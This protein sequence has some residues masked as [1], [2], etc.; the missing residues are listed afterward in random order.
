MKTTHLSAAALVASVAVFAAHPARAEEADE[1]TPQGVRFGTTA[2]SP[3][4]V[5]SACSMH[6]SL[7]VEGRPRPLDVQVDGRRCTATPAPQDSI[8]IDV[9]VADEHVLVETAVPGLSDE[10]TRPIVVAFGRELR[11]RVERAMAPSPQVTYTPLPMPR[12]VEGAPADH[13]TK[14]FSPA[15]IGFGITS[16]AIGG[17][18]VIGGTIGAIS[19]I[20]GYNTGG[21]AS[22]VGWLVAGAGITAGLG[23]PLVLVGKR[24]V[25]NVVASVAPTGGSLRV[26]F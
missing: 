20:G 13:E 22:G 23:L 6:A 4:I 8:T 3:V 2:P 21:V 12:V 18:M 24:K 17:L 7:T 26:A 14:V 16:M 25:P 11:N 15:M 5:A 19:N 1:P 9:V 10:V